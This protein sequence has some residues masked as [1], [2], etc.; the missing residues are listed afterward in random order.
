MSHLAQIN[1]AKMLA[2]LDSPIMADFVANLER[3]NALADDSPGFIW[4]LQG[5]ED[6]A[7]ALR[8]FE[9][10]YL[11]VNMSV[12]TSIDALF[13]FTYQSAHKEIFKR[14]KEWFSKMQ[15]MHMACWYIPKGHEPTTEEAKQRLAYLNAHGETPYAFTFK[16][17]VTAEEAASF[18][19]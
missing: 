9:D 14:K 11:I 16:N 19:P 1:I 8:V 13:A 2:P 10:N 18:S 4:R 17:K 7:T 12:W 15:E 6:N 3:I 5:E